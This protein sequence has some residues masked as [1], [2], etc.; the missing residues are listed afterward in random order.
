MCVVHGRAPSGGSP[1]AH[2]QL[3]LLRRLAARSLPEN[4]PCDDRSWIAAGETS[5]GGRHVD[6]LQLVNQQ[7]LPP[8]LPMPLCIAYWRALPWD[9]MHREYR[10]HQSQC[11][12]APHLGCQVVKTVFKAQTVLEL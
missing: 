11:E 7:T 3:L 10:G 1:A 12:D 8:R 2:W 5:V 4:H 9:C 6:H